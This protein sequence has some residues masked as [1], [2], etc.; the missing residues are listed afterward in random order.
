MG[1]YIGRVMR[2]PGGGDV[3]VKPSEDKNETSKRS[4]T[5]GTLEAEGQ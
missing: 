2:R 1:A 5:R 3:S 4:G